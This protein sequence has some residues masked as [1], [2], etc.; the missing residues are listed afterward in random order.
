[1]H[2]R[3]RNLQKVEVSYFLRVLLKY[4]IVSVESEIKWLVLK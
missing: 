4:L 2:L 1:M 3:K